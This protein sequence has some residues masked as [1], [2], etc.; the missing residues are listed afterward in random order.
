M[1]AKA[2]TIHYGDFVG[3]CQV[4][5]ND[6]Q[7]FGTLVDPNGHSWLICTGCIKGLWETKQA[8]NQEAAQRQVAEDFINELRDKLLGGQ[9]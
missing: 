9:P 3:I 7:R 8:L 1:S 2:A 6:A 5:F 4:C